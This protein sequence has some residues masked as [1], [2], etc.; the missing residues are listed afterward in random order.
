MGHPA[1]AGGDR[2]DSVL[3]RKK[4]EA[5][6]DRL[7]DEWTVQFPAEEVMLK[8]QAAGVPAGVVQNGAEIQ[9]TPNWPIENTHRS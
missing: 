9:A 1:R 5:E 4:H 8:L 7:M 2:F 3:G 6:L